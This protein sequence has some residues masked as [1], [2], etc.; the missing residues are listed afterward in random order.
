MGRRTC[1]TVHRGES[2]QPLMDGVRAGGC[3]RATILSARPI[4]RENPVIRAADAQRGGC[5]KPPRSARPT[6]VPTRANYPT[7]NQLQLVPKKCSMG[8]E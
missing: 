4:A 8:D 2:G 3:R 1:S 7:L 5:P 6:P